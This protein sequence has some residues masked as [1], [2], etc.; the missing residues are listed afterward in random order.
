VGGSRS[1]TFATTVVKTLPFR[2]PLVFGVLSDT[3]RWDR[4]MGI[5]PTRYH[6]EA[7]DPDDPATRTRVGTVG[8]P[9]REVTF[10]EEGECWV[11]RR[12][13]GERVFL[14]KFA[15]RMPRA[16][17]EVEA[18]A[19][20]EST[21]ITMRAGAE[22][23]TL[24]GWLLGVLVLWRCW[25][26]LRRY[27]RAVEQV[28]ARA[29]DAP[30]ETPPATQAKRA[31]LATGDGGREV[32]G[33]HSR[34]GAEHATRAARFADAPVDGKLRDRLLAFLTEQPDEALVQIRPFEVAA[35]WGADRREVL[36]TFLHAARVGLLELEWQ[37][38]CPTCRVG[39]DWAPHLDRLG[40]RVHCEECDISFDVDFADNVEATFTVSPAVREVPRVVWCAS[41]PFWRPH[42]H[43]FLTVPPRTSRVIGPLPACA[44]L[45]RARGSARQ[46]RCDDPRRP[47][48]VRVT[49]EAIVRTEAGEAAA[50]DALVIENATD[51]PV[52]FLVER[53][54][55]TADRVLGRLLLGLPDFVTLFGTEA[56][57]TG[58]QLSVGSMAVLFTDVVG[59]TELYETLGDA[60]AFALV[61]RHWRS[62]EAAAAR[63]HGTVLK[64]LGDGLFCCFGGLGDAAA[65]AI[66]MMAAAEQLATPGVR[67]AIRAAIHEGPTYL[68]RASERLDLFGSTVNLASRLMT[69]TAGSQLAMLASSAAHPGVAAALEETGAL[70]QTS[71]TRLRGLRGTYPV[72]IATRADAAVFTT[73]EHAPVVA[74]AP[75][76]QSPAGVS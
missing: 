25:F 75:K 10:L 61:Q 50:A 67:F 54:D 30:T 49:D 27:V 28:L 43:G 24:R 9:T 19:D 68:V 48:A 56:P 46:L 40:Q 60:R 52:R 15:R 45:L 76:A 64:T 72:A 6:Y 37:I 47:L 22:V 16:F 2:A 69:V 17:L 55:W 33:D 34:M 35:A 12:L 74:R 13:H 29:P 59:S 51:R 38:D 14:G 20:G 62:C 66:E 5:P 70:L 71:E 42:V 7:L 44:V 58:L 57:A 21:R 65:A 63:H 31:L 3:N 32:S 4:L 23:R 11:P 36:R 1:K 18:V 39:A 26:A 41:S 53:A 73:G 8:R